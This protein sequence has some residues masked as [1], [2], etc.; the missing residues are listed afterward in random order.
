MIRGPED[1][2][3]EARDMILGAIANLSD[4]TPS[5]HTEDHVR[6]AKAGLDGA[7]ADHD[8]AGGKGAP[9]SALLAV[10]Y[11]DAVAWI[12]EGICAGDVMF[13]PNTID[14]GDGRVHAVA[15]LFRR[16]EGDVVGDARKEARKRWKALKQKGATK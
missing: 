6:A 7:L 13:P 16:S 2:P 4:Y 11:E 12:V 5:R 9:Q 8:A 14:E 3:D 15:G 10:A 1:D